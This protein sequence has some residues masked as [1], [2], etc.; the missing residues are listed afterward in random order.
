VHLIG[1]AALEEGSLRV[2]PNRYQPLVWIGWI[3]LLLFALLI[4]NRPAL[5]QEEAGE[6]VSV[7]GVVEVWRK[8]RW[9]AVGVGEAVAVGEVVR[10]GEGSRIALQLVNGSQIKLNA[11]TQLEL[12]QIA[13]EAGLAPAP[14]DFP[15]NILRL[16]SGEAWIRGNNESL[17][18][19][20]VPATATIRGTEFNLAV[21][22]GDVV[23]LAVLDGQVELSN[24]QGSVLVAANEQATAKLGE[25]PRKT[26]LLDP[27]DAVQWSLYYPDIMGDREDRSRTGRA[28][29][30]SPR[31]WT[32]AARDHL[33]RGQ[34]PAARQALDRALA[35]DRN[36]AR[37][38]S[39][40]AA[41]ELVQNRKAEARADAER[42]VTADPASPEAHL[43][44]SWVQ[45][46]EFDLDSALTS[47][48]EA[49]QLAPDDSQALIQES[50]LLFGMGRLGEAVE[51][52]KQ[53]R[54]RAPNDAMVNT[55]W[56]FLELARN[57][58][59]K[60]RTAFEAAI[61]QD[62]T[63]GLPHLG[64]GL[65]LF[66]RNR[67]DAAVAEMRKATLLDPKV[68]LY[69]SYLGK[70]YYEVKDDRLAQKYLTEAKQLDPH[71]PTPH[72]Y[73]AIRQQSVNRPV[74]AVES[75]QRSIELN[76]DRGVYRSRLL[77]D[78]DRAARAA[79]LGRVYNEVGFTELGLRE[80]WQSVDRDP[81][82]YS[83][84]RLLAD[85]YAA[86]P[87]IE[88]ART[89]ELLQAQLLQPINITPVSPRM[90]ETK[91]LMPSAGPITPSLYEFN[92]L[93]VRNRPTL[94]FSGLG[95]N[96]DT[97]G[98]ELVVSGL[99]DR[100]AYSLGQLHYQ[101]DGYRPNNDLENNLYNLF[102][103][104]AV[105]PDF[106]LQAEYRHR[107]TISGYLESNFDGFFG[108]SLRRNLDQD[109]A[110]IGARYSLSPQTTVIASII[111]T[112]RDSISSS[113]IS[114]FT[115]E[116]RQKGTQAE[117]QLL[118]KAEP[119]NM[120]TGFGAYSLDVGET[121]EIGTNNTQQIA[122]S[123][124]NIKIPDNVIWTVGLSYESDE[125]PFANLNELNPK[126]GVQWAV[127]DR[128]SL[129]AAAFKTVKRALAFEQ[130]IEPTQVAGFNQLT[131]YVDTTVAK[132]YGV[133]LD[134]RFSDRFFG[135]LEALRRYTDVPLGE[136]SHPESYEVINNK[137]DFY[138]AYL[139]WLP[140]HNWALSAS[141]RY[142]KLE[143]DQDCAFCLFL[144]P[145][146][147]KTFS[148]PASVQ[149]FDPSGFFAGLG[150]TYVNQDI[151][152]IDRP[153]SIPRSFTLTP[154]QNEEFTLV[155]VGLGYRL[156]K[157]WGIVALQVNNVFDQEFHYQDYSFQT[158]TSA[159]NP[160]Y[161]PERTI[162][163]RLILNF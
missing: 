38:Y 25:A 12:K 27:L 87:G 55:I 75:L 142:E 35:L 47:A 16:L 14:T 31:Y 91:L 65:A 71:D 124:A 150:I 80:G 21:D 20:T 97:W 58:V 118:Y 161:V 130:T 49:V 141:L 99:T 132:N 108:R 125:S 8:G 54:Q 117:A 15:H 74:E 149:Y 73:D 160:V 28:D 122:Y 93:F 98:D 78:E 13:A 112:D 18:V 19:Q 83:A 57:R 95:G 48:H 139:Y 33:L 121:D 24:P 143:A 66:R 30:K 128:V 52:T 92:P 152:A 1:I 32:Q 129:R 162:V 158:G 4:P 44:M 136:L 131:D 36:D 127:T 89:S 126:F 144:Y 53:A 123:Y 60:A 96:Q 46:A 76:D 110:R 105:T 155:D 23:R 34:V 82:N 85:S 70:A 115:L 64:L 119:F 137:E 43:A 146:E 116:N 156:P 113:S 39:L 134:A 17:R 40:R 138:S 72:Y 62:S 86:L 61:A 154:T 69:N 90:A 59:S 153:S 3:C 104:T 103:Q 2:G 11:N 145:A 157:R 56:G 120:I 148:L 10:T 94:F 107:E 45:Q 26:V 81:T 101:S 140:S 51:I 63:L 42:A 147:L 111:H 22:P 109:T 41:V 84:H 159:I 77:L 37:A 6:I 67:T 68:S 106:S 79:T 9:Q 29:P 7:L 102:V 88:A 151:Q 163:G 133:A 5:A 100:F 114:N 50:S 135:G